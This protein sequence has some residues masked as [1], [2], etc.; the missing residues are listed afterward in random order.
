MI[1]KRT[2]LYHFYLLYFRKGDLLKTIK[3]LA[4]NKTSPFDNIPIKVLKNSIHI[5]SEKLTFSMNT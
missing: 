4:S 1:L 5:Y 2:D 3:C